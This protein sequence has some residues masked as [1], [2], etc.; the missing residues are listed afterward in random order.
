VASSNTWDSSHEFVEFTP[1]KAGAYTIKVR[2]FSIP[3]DFF[4]YYGVAWTTH[5]DIC[6]G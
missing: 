2:G 4:S 6:A 3:A 5:Y 1:K